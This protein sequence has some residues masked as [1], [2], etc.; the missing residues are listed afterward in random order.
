MCYYKTRNFFI[1][2]FSQ[3]FC[4]NVWSDNKTKV[5]T[6]CQ[7]VSIRISFQEHKSV[8]S[9]RERSILAVRMT[10]YGLLREPIR[11]LLFIKDML[12]HII[13]MFSECVDNLCNDKPDQ[14]SYLRKGQCK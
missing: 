10:K 11:M 3:R 13:T 1:R 14:K 12:R 2:P 4:Q 9:V 7:N 8:K 6:S 5:S